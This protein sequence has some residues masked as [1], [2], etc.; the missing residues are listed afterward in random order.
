VHYKSLSVVHRTRS[1]TAA[2]GARGA[3]PPSQGRTGRRNLSL[4]PARRS[5][6]QSPAARKALPDRRHR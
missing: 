2:T 6:G 5:L 4:A 1:Q 3:D